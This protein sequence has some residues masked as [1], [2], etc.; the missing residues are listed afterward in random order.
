[1]KG[2]LGLTIAACLG[3]LGGL[4]NWFYIQQKSRDLEKVEFIAVRSQLEINVGDTF[5]KSNF[6][7]VAIPKAH[8][9]N[10][11]ATAVK[12]DLLQTVIGKNATRYYSGGNLIL[13]TELLEPP[14]KEII[15]LLGENEVLKWIPIDTRTAVPEHINPGNETLTRF[16]LLNLII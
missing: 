5:E 3:I 14:S 12:W 9:G 10:L 7:P 2:P 6:E 13:H 4:C 1:M 8:L 16:V 15:S 11:D